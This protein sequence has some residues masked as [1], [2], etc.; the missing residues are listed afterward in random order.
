MRKLNLTIVA[1]IIAA[2]VGGVLVLSYGRG[3]DSKIANG[4]RTVAVLV[5]K[6]DLVAG[7][8]PAALRDKVEVRQVPA[9][10]AV[11]D[12]LASLDAIKATDVLRLPVTASGQIGRS[13]FGSQAATLGLVPAKGKVDI[14]IRVGLVPGVAKYVGAGSTVDMFVTYK[15]LKTDAAAFSV[16]A[17]PSL[18]KLFASGVSVVAVT[19]APPVSSSG[20]PNGAV[21][22]VGDDV[23]AIVEVTPDLA[24]K[25][26]NA[27]SIGEIYLALSAIGDVHSTPTGA[28]PN[29]VLGNNR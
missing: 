24:Q 7:E 9:E 10:Y 13:A 27:Q 20:Q 17:N 18:T 2:L 1:G 12:A 28:S 11:S 19:A 6:T 3:V 16:V 4:R 29:G 26:I 25:I 21:P 14:A 22:V 15:A 8:L 5:A 23:L